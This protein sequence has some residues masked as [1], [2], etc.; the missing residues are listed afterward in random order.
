LTVF[1]L[2]LPSGLLAGSLLFPSLF[3]ILESELASFLTVLVAALVLF[4]PLLLALEAALVVVKAP[5]LSSLTGQD[6]F[7]AIFKA[8]KLPEAL[9]LVGRKR[10]TPR[11][12][13][14]CE[15]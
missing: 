2:L 4:K 8:L 9:T 14:R 12:S 15:E 5:H 11:E 3:L 10:F 13:G 7:L 6:P 1:P